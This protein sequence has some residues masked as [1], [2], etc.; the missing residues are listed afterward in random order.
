MVKEFKE[1]NQKIRMELIRKKVGIET[2]GNH[3]EDGK[4]DP[5]HLIYIVITLVKDERSKKW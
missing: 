1:E 2:E 3:K 4:M 5:H